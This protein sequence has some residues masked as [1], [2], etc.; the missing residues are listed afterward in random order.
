MALYANQ[1]GPESIQY[2]G[3]I[4]AVLASVEV[5][6]AVDGTLAIL[7]TD[8]T[9]S[10]TAANPLV[11]DVFGNLKFFADPDEYNIVIGGATF[12]ITLASHPKEPGG[13]GFQ[14]SY[15]HTQSTP[16]TVWTVQHNL[17]RRP[18]SITIFSLDYS[19][20][21]DG[22]SILHQDVNRLLVSA[23]VAF[24]GIALIE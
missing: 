24:S 20:Q 8:K 23:D 22:F 18:S 19:Q 16:A 9:K 15:A 2:P 14:I 4:P 21:F 17:G 12:A 1:W 7:Y 11:T 3:R 13:A 5:R 6:K 10:V